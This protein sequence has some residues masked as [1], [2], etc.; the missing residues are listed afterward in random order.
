M[1]QLIL[2]RGLPG[3][4]KTTLAKQLV[5]GASE[6]AKHCEADRFFYKPDRN[7]GL[8]YVFDPSKLPEAHANCLSRTEHALKDGRSVVVSNTFTQRWEME[9]YLKLYAQSYQVKDGG[10][11]YPYHL[12]VIDLFD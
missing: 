2:I 11:S 6:D 9:G 4:G 5:A 12:V 7:G 1:Q 8:Q 10:V 3:T